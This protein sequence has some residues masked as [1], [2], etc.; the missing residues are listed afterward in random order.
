[1]NRAQRFGFLTLIFLLL[2]FPFVRFA[3]AD[4][5]LPVPPEDLA[6]KDNPKEP[7]A[8]AMILY[9]Q[10]IVDASKASEGGDTQ[11]EYVRIK[12]FT[13]TGTKYG[14]VEIDFQDQIDTVSYVA[15]RT[16]HPDGT[17]VKFDGQVLQTILE[18]RSGAKFLAKS[19]TLP[20]VQPGCII[21]YKYQLRGQPDMVQDWGWTITQPIYTRQAQFT[22]T[23]YLGYG[24]GLRPVDRT[25]LLPAG[26]APKQIANGSY[27]MVVNDIPGVVDEPLMPPEKPIEARVDFQ[28]VSQ[29]EPS[30]TEPSD[31]YWNEYGKKIDANLERFIDKKSAL[32]QALS[33][34]VSPADPPET[35]LRKIYVRVQQLR[36]LNLEDA[37]TRQENKDENVKPNDN[38]EDV[39]KRGYGSGRQ[40]NYLFV[41]LARSAGFDATE[42]YVAPRNED[43]FIPQRND[44]EQLTDDLVWVHAGSQDYYLDPAARYFPFGL[45]PWYET[46][47]RGIR[48]DK[49]GATMANTPDP[50]SPDATIVRKG[51]LEIKNDGSIGGTVQVDFT[52]LRAAVA[53]EDERKE[54]ETGRIK[55]FEDQIQSWL[56]VGSVFRIAKIENWENTEQPVHVEGTLS[57]PS[58]GSGATQRMLMPLEVFQPS[59]MGDFAAEKRVNSVYFHYP[60]EEIDDINFH[61]PLGYKV[62]SLPA[63]GKVN[64]GPISYDISAVA[65]T[66]IVEVKRHLV[67]GSVLFTK[68]NYPILRQIFGI[69]RT[70]DNSRMVLQNAQP[71]GN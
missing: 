61:M 42:L 65:Q 25:Y 32:D 8:D 35:K 3:A 13:Q 29:D 53:R 39:L 68:D 69:V 56:P 58:F 16:I 11:E 57:M 48:V 17:I 38:V 40:I 19:F 44:A 1:M 27:V 59:Q 18:K 36:N 30:P 67:I 37:K 10:V 70:D 52:G 55:Y 4:D 34:I 46:E 63:E 23:P 51:D 41:G 2:L 9:R 21:E 49:H 71:S 47:V 6:L 5:W 66:D 62:Q 20:D 50:A 33:T 54:D 12:V 43:V 45:L 24:S 15:G 60:Y 64:A 7:G 28:Y 26:T 22:Y 31:H 14:H